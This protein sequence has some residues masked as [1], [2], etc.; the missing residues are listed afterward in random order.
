MPSSIT[1]SLSTNAEVDSFTDVLSNDRVRYQRKGYGLVSA[2]LIT[3][4]FFLLLPTLFHQYYQ[5]FLGLWSSLEVGV[6]MGTVLLDVG[7]FWGLNMAMAGI[8]HIQH[9]FFEKYKTNL[10]PWPWVADPAEWTL[11]LKRTLWTLALNQMV[12]LPVMLA[13][14]VYVEGVQL[15]VELRDFPTLGTLAAQVTFCMFIEDLSFYFGHRILHTRHLYHLIHKQHHEY[16]TTI[17]LASFYAHPFEFVFANMLPAALGPKLLGSSCHLVT[18]WLWNILRTAETIDGHCGYDFSWSPF[19]LLP[20]SGGAV[21]HD[22]HHSH[23]VGNFGSFFSLWDSVFN[24]NAC[25]FRYL[26]VQQKEQ[27]KTA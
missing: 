11:S 21:Y 13:L 16:T 3:C 4:A 2:L 1:S 23:N 20:L 12:M 9:P 27:D 17:G 19:R 24:T 5:Q 6:I 14:T 22:F 15:S 26:A 10:H 8:Y 25:Y 7:V 18:F